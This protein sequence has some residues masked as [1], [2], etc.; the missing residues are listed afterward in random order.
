MQGWRHNVLNA[1]LLWLRIL[2]GLTIAN[3]GYAKIFKGGLAQLIPGV[4]ALGFPA[5]VVFAWLAAL[6][7]FV[8]GLLIVI[9]LGTRGAA[10][11]IFFTMCVAFFGAHAQDPFHVKLPAF[12]YGTIA[13]TLMLTGAGRFSLD[14]LLCRKGCKGSG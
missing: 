1:G 4:E 5:P 6:S 10:F 12:L 8:G 14:S 3:I 9:G 13:G 2:M 11:F 7:E